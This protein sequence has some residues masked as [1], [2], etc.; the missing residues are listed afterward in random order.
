MRIERATLHHLRIP[1]RRPFEHALHRRSEAEMVI[2]RTIDDGDIA[3]TASL[4]EGPGEV[5]P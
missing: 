4:E 5:P 2:V 3:F 1:L